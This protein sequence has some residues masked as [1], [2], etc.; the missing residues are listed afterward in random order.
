MSRDRRNAEGRVRNAPADRLLRFWAEELDRL[1]DQYC[2]QLDYEGF[3][4]LTEHAAGLR[5]VATLL[6]AENRDKHVALLVE[7]ARDHARFI[8]DAFD[9]EEGGAS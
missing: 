9:G 2:E 7:Q 8:E 3:A 6:G 5:A 1:A 4:G